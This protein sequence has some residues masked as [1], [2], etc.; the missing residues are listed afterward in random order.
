MQGRDARKGGGP[1]MPPTVQISSVDAGSGYP[2]RSFDVPNGDC[3]NN[4]GPEVHERYRRTIDLKPTLI[5]E[6]KFG[7]ASVKDTALMFRLVPW[8]NNYMMEIKKVH[9]GTTEASIIIHDDYGFTPVQ[10]TQSMIFGSTSV[11]ATFTLLT[12]YRDQ[13]IDS[14]ST[15]AWKAG[16]ALDAV[17]R[18]M[19]RHIIELY[20]CHDR[21][22]YDSVGLLVRQRQNY[23]VPNST[24]KS[25]IEL[26]ENRGFNIV[27]RSRWSVKLSR[28]REEMLKLYD[29]NKDMEDEIITGA[30]G[31]SIFITDAI[32]AE[33]QENL[34]Q[35]YVIWEGD[36]EPAGSEVSTVASWEYIGAPGTMYIRI[37]NIRYRDMWVNWLESRVMRH[38]H[39]FFPVV[40]LVP[41]GK[42]GEAPPK[43][44]A[45]GGNFMYSNYDV[46][47]LDF[48][49]SL[50]ASP[51]ERFYDVEYLP[52]LKRVMYATPGDRSMGYF[53]KRVNFDGWFNTEILKA[54]K[55]ENANNWKDFGEFLGISFGKT[56]VNKSNGRSKAIRNNSTNDWKKELFA[57]LKTTT[58]AAMTTTIKT[59][60][61]NYLGNGSNVI[62]VME[63]LDA[64]ADEVR[65]GHDSNSTAMYD[66]LLRR[67]IDML[68]AECLSLYDICEA[69]RLFE[70]PQPFGICVRRSPVLME[71]TIL[72]F[73]NYSAYR[74]EDEIDVVARRDPIQGQVAVTFKQDYKD[75]M[76]DPRGVQHIEGAY[77]IPGGHLEY[78]SRGGFG[79]AAFDQ[80]STG[81]RMDSMTTCEALRGLTGHSVHPVL[82]H[83]AANPIEFM[84]TIGYDD[85]A[86][87]LICGSSSVMLST[88]PTHRYLSTSDIA[89]VRLGIMDPFTNRR[90]NHVPY[91]DPNKETIRVKSYSHLMTTLRA[92]TGKVI[93]SECGPTKDRPHIYHRDPP[94]VAKV[95]GEEYAYA[96]QQMNQM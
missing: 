49:V 88:Q 24:P 18:H 58:S 35:L 29:Y 45:N 79:S 41:V 44:S 48:A 9:R 57:V 86:F 20:M 81:N 71:H 21:V 17:V 13:S 22:P 83:E 34:E 60:F 91:M 76:P 10:S 73:K 93:S 82:W 46:K 85:A 72:F 68:D 43:S 69:L 11:A 54:A 89:A 5:S 78:G 67:P 23:A 94:Q 36:L 50:H 53:D 84:S 61:R 87:D 15:Y 62:R 4:P 31:S 6:I 55:K 25:L 39:T 63:F 27:R 65:E 77:I 70:L 33:A 92:M 75:Y 90:R 26:F 74:Q 40:T 14:D 19:Q 56:G 64:L 32:L 59:N 95:F 7:K 30:S 12:D 38:Q 3:V 28:Y 96:Q 1:L 16:Q 80:Y 2:A 8:D 66:S 37:T 52:G 51:D 47:L 42:Q